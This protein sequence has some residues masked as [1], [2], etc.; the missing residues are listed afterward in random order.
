[1]KT[2]VLATLMVTALSISYSAEVGKLDAWRSDIEYLK[3][4]LPKRHKN[5]FFAVDRETFESRLDELSKSLSGRADTEIVL[6][7]QEIIAAMGDDHTNIDCRRVLQE[8]GVFPLTL[9][10][11]SDGLYVLGG[12]DRYESAFGH[13]ITAI[14][15]VPIEEVAMRLSSLVTRTNDSL[16][17]QRIPGM[18]LS[19]GLLRHCDVIRGDSCEFAFVDKAGVEQ[20]IVV[21][22]LDITKLGPDTKFGGVT[23]ESQPLF[24]Q[25]QRLPF[26]CE[27]MDECKILYA[28]YNRCWSRELEEEHGSKTAAER[29]PSF[30]EF[31]SKILEQVSRADTLK[32]VLDLRSNGGGSSPQG[33]ELAKAI[34]KVDRINK[35]GRLFVIIGPKTY[36]SAVIN[37]IDFQKHTEAILVGEPT[38][39]KPNHYGEVN[40]FTLPKTGLSVSYSTD[41]FQLLDEDPNSLVPD[42]TVETTFADYEAGRDPALEEIRRYTVE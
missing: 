28:N 4:E 13:R 41:Y 20:S 8:A 7:L 21:E 39:G 25:N 11:F 10:W 16:V 1:M 36:S 35:K 24:R 30:T 17:R 33:T 23:P 40:K 14:G 32:F 31:R 37:A 29:L 15:D 19:I 34:G 22:K 2:G 12:L 6:S 38:S 5:L 3:E 26:W 9:Y 42:I 27:F 18:L